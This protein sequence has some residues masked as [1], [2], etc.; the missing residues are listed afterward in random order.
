MKKLLDA[1]FDIMHSKLKTVLSTNY[2]YGG[3]K[4]CETEFL[5]L[6]T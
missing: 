2:Y 1:E 4:V 6:W 3:K 5:P